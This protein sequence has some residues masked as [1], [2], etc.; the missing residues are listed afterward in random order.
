MAKARSDAL[1]SLPNRRAFDLEIS[2]RLAQRKRQGVPLCLQIIDIDNFKTCND[3]F[4][5]QVGDAILKKVAKVLA[6][7]A[8]Q[9]DIV[10]RLG[11]DEFAVLHPGISLEEA[12]RAADRFRSAIADTPLCCDGCQHELTISTGVAEAHK[13]DDAKSLIQRADE[14]LYAAKESGKNSVTVACHPRSLDRRS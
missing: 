11:G 7:T 14:A 4:G 2:R 8:R 1:T 9:M 3:G 10:A 13:E 6:S 5:H 12:S